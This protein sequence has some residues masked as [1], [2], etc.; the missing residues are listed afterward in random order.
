MVDF[1]KLKSRSGSLE[2]AQ[3]AIEAHKT[4]YDSED[5]SGKYWKASLD[6]SNNGEAVIRFLPPSSVDGDDAPAFVK[7]YSHGFEANGWLIDNCP[8]SIG[9]KCPVCDS[10]TALW[11]TGIK[12]NQDIAR[13][14][15]RKLSYVSNIYV[16][17]DP[18][19]PENEGKVFLYRYGQKIF[20]KIQLA[21]KPAFK[22]D[23]QFD[24]FDLW[25]GANFKMRIVKGQYGWDYAASL[26][27]KPAPLVDD[28]AKL[29]EV[30]SQEYGLLELIA[31]DKFKP[32]DIIKKRLDTVL[33]TS[34][35]APQQESAAPPARTM[36]SLRKHVSDPAPKMSGDDDEDDMKFFKSLADE[37]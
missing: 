14:R 32:Y 10:N 24:A 8:T 28:D 16:I 12:A 15:K 31:A 13:D 18:L 4:T 1:A 26:F 20:E 22:S 30:W 3:K 27:D 7:Y 11:A 5:E 29:Q 34:I 33:G 2:K 17:S 23:P 19:H 37:S 21:L 6:K 35:P 36:E 9:E 25:A